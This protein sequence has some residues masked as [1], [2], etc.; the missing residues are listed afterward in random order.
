LEQSKHREV[1]IQL[2]ATPVRYAR[3]RGNV[4]NSFDLI[5]PCLISREIFRRCGQRLEM[6]EFGAC[7]VW[8]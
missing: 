2:L 3:F 1:D 6:M 8:N 4:V 5:P 7:S